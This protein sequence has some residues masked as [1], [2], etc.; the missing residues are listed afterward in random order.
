MERATRMAGM[1][2]SSA[3]VMSSIGVPMAGDMMIPSEPSCSSVS[4]KVR[5]FSTES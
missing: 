4:M 5:C 3:S 1:P 2:F